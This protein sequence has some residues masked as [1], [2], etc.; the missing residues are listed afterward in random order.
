MVT[1]VYQHCAGPVQVYKAVKVHGLRRRE[2]PA[3]TLGALAS[4][5]RFVWFIELQWEHEME[6]GWKLQKCRVAPEFPEKG[7]F[8]LGEVVARTQWQD[9]EDD[10]G[11][12]RGQIG[13][14]NLM[15]WA[16]RDSPAPP[17]GFRCLSRY[18]DRLAVIHGLPRTP[19]LLRHED[20][21]AADLGRASIVARGHRW[22]HCAQ[23]PHDHMW[24]I[25]LMRDVGVP[26]R[27]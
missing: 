15:L 8:P 22:G 20:G 26:T 18:S 21:T 16:N 9:M 6:S 10:L 11:L 19:L 13:I 24:P 27:L 5:C 14:S 12:P 3:T 7:M 23:F 25:V 4:R 17:L 1:N 2:S